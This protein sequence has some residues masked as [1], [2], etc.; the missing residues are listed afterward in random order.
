MGR[1][2][3]PSSGKQVKKGYDYGLDIVGHPVVSED[4]HAATQPTGSVI[5]YGF[6]AMALSLI[7]V[8]LFAMHSCNKPGQKMIVPVP[9]V[10]P[11]Q[12]PISSDIQEKSG[13]IDDVIVIAPGK[14]VYP[15][16]PDGVRC[17]AILTRRDVK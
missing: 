5:V 10:Q 9:V 7:A 13:K 11:I 6:G 16:V 15:C 4:E 1:K 3:Q 14:K 8:G 17:G 2:N 12:R